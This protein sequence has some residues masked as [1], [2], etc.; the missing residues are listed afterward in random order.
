MK[1]LLLLAALS[2]LLAPAARA[3]VIVYD[4]VETFYEPDTQPYDTIFIGSFEFDTDTQ[5]VSNLHGFLTEAM[6]GNASR[7]SLDH[8]L[9]AVY[10]P[11]LGGLLVTTFRNASTS[12]LTTLFGGDGWTPG[13]DEGSGLHYDF[14]DENPGNAYARIFVNLTNPASPLTQAQ[15]DRLAY[16]DCTDGGMMGAVC[17]TGT[18]VAGYGFVGTMSGYPVSQTITPV[19]PEPASAV[20]LAAGAGALG[21]V[22]RRRRGNA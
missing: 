22:S 5:A 12:T 3:S 18:S 1:R 14:P 19:V 20:L 15:I 13:S 17:M 8:Q 16:A 2:L 9:S 6:T 4:V 21:L 11:G 7:V 10:D